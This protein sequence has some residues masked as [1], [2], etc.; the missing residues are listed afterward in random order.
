MASTIVTDNVYDIY[1]GDSS[2]AFTQKTR[3]RI[4]WICSQVS[5]T[6]ILDVGCSQGIV[7]LLLGRSG[8]TVLGIDILPESISY[9]EKL[10]QKE[11]S[12]VKKC[13][14]FQCADFMTLKLEKKYDSIILTEVLEHILFVD[15]FLQ[16]ILSALARKGTLIVTVPFGIN[17]YWDHKRTYYLGNL[18]FSLSPLFLIREIKLFDSWIGIVCSRR[19]KWRVKKTHTPSELLEIEETAFYRRERSLIDDKNKWKNA[20]HDQKDK[21]LSLQEQIG[22][23]KQKNEQLQNDARRWRESSN[24]YKEKLSQSSGKDISN[25]TNPIF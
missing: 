7:P 23:L 4:N 11:D 14:S 3:E 13:V 22:I 17:D 12:S 9:A 19:K 20:F 8:K 2:S 1:M 6:T 21:L 18:Y 5:G 10:L 16:K 24:S 15:A 25:N